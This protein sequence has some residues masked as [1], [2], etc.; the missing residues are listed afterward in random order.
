MDDYWKGTARGTDQLLAK[1]EVEAV[2]RVGVARR[3]VP[4]DE[5]HELVRERA[6]LGESVTVTDIAE[7]FE[8][9]KAVAQRAAR[10]ASHPATQRIF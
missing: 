3:L 9:P 2:P 6:S 7:H 4:F 8:V 5:L 1:V 10:M